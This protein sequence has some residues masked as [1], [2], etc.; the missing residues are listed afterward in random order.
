[1]EY[2][3]GEE[4]RKFDIGKKEI[5]DPVRALSGYYYWFCPRCK[6]VLDSENGHFVHKCKC[7]NQVIDWSKV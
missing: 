2:M 1:M 7:C 5:S 3:D 6:K 4:I